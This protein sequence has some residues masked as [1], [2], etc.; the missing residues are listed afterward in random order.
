MFLERKGLIGWICLDVCMYVTPLLR[1]CKTICPNEI[2][3]TSQPEREL[4]A[5][6]KQALSHWEFYILLINLKS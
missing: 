5:E 4:E 6:V 1:V 3:Q 2:D